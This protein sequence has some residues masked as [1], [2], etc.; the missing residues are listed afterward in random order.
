M[1]K[2]DSRMILRDGDS[3]I[4]VLQVFVFLEEDGS[5]FVELTFFSEDV[6]RTRD[7]ERDFI[8]WVEGL[9]ITLK[10]RRAFARYVGAGWVFGDTGQD[11][12]V[13]LVLPGNDP[14]TGKP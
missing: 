10:A 14:R 13:F 9:R 12:G 2:V 4:R 11:S 6:V 7:I 5:P 8:G 1:S 3:P